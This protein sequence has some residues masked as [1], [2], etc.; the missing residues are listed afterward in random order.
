MKFSHGF[1]V[2]A[3][4]IDEQG[5][6]NNVAYV[7]W[8]Q[9]AAVAHWFSV[10]SAEIRE[11][12]TW[13]LTR[14]EIDYKKQTFAGEKVTVTTWVGEPRKVLWERFTEIRRGEDLLVKARSVWC[15]IDKI[16]GRP[17]KIGSAIREVLTKP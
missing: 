5:H 6:V 12:F 3:E 8:I 11:K 10:T 15:L 13:V 14:H 7:R 9:D 2:L 4:D 17:S 1:S 16:S